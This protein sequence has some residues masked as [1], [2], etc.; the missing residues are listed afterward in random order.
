MNILRNITKAGR[1]LPPNTTAPVDP[2]QNCPEKN[3]DVAIFQVPFGWFTKPRSDAVTYNTIDETVQLLHSLFGAKVIILQTVPVGNNLQ[4]FETELIAINNVIQNYTDTFQYKDGMNDYDDDEEEEKNKNKDEDEGKEKSE[5]ENEDNDI[6]DSIQAV[7]LMDMARF[8]IELFKHNAA[9]LG[10]ITLDPTNN[11]NNEDDEKFIIDQLNPLLQFRTGCCHYY[12]PQII[13]FTCAQNVKNMTRHCTRTKYSMDGHHWCLD[14][15][16]G[17]VHGVTACLIK[18]GHDFPSMK[19]ELEVCQTRCN[20]Q[21]M[22]L[23]PIP[24]DEDG[25]LENY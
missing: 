22:S 15:V 3:F 6:D 10:L 8:S 25:V 4:N 17:R 7:L 13:G 21:Y 19:E 23:R 20:E 16:G 9:S 11:N 24:F 12:F 2:L 1:Y 5:N 18:C 14:E